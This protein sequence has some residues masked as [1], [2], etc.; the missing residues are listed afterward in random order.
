MKFIKLYFI[1]VEI[2]Q[3]LNRKHNIV[4]DVVMTLH[5]SAYVLYDMVISLLW[6]DGIH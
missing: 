5:A 1:T 3:F 6:D 4:M 2:E